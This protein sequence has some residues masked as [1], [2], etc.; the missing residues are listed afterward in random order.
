MALETDTGTANDVVPTEHIVP[1]IAGY[2]FPVLTADAVCWV[3]PSQG[4]GSTPIVF[5]RWASLAV[6]AGTNAEVDDDLTRVEASTDGE[7]VTPG[8]VGF[9]LSITDVLVRGS[10]VPGI[11]ES[12]LQH[13]LN[14]LAARRDAD[15][16]SAITSAG[17][18]FSDTST[19]LTREQAKRAILR[20]GVKFGINGGKPAFILSSAAHAQLSVDELL[21]SATSAMYAEIFGPSAGFLGEWHGALLFHSAQCPANGVGYSSVITPIGNGQSGLGLGEVERVNVEIN[22]GAEGARAR[23]TFA[24]VTAWYGAG[25]SNDDRVLEVASQA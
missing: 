6:P 4:S 3:E 11:A 22:R 12:A 15:I 23:T 17:E 18:T 5:P 1:F 14:A 25:L 24:A 8:V 2:N 9:E 20:A 19:S 13:S 10:R 7:T 21:S 16:L